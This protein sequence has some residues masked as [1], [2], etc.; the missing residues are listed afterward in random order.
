MSA[1]I[2]GKAGSAKNMKPRPAPPP[3]VADL[4]G[5]LATGWEVVSDGPSGVKLQGERTMRLLD[6]LA[7]AVGVVLLPFWWV[8]GA[9]LVGIAVIDYLALTPRKTV[10][11]QR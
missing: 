11:L 5:L 7:L 3:T 10:F 4:P 2:Y 1:K 6:K 8:A 9:V